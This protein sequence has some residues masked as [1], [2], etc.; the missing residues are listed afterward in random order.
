M[1]FKR[2]L[3]A[4]QGIPADLLPRLNRLTAS[5][6]DALRLARTILASR[7]VYLFAVDRTWTNDKLIP[8]FDWERSED[9][10]AALWQGYAWN[11]R[12][13]A[14]LWAALRPLLL[15]TFTPERLERLHS[16]AG[17]LA[18]LL[19]MVGVELPSADVP[20]DR[21]RDAIRAMP[22]EVRR[23]A[24][25]WLC[26]HVE[27]AKIEN[28]TPAAKAALDVRADRL[29]RERVAPWLMRVW[30]RNRDL[31][32]K[33]TSEQFASLAIATEDAFDEAV[34]LL[35]PFMGEAP[36]WGF[37]IQELEDSTHPELRP[38]SSLKLI[39]RLISPKGAIFTT[40]LRVVLDRITKS[41]PSLQ[42]DST[43]R[44]LDAALRT[45]GG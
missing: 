40:S 44:A 23:E 42:Q 21:V 43:Y 32:H 18:T 7:L 6:P 34:E 39:G 24:I 22:P 1:T 15:N 30:P 3:R 5:H 20:A 37:P 41:D 17:N 13:N 28:P 45:V 2:G 27:G 12:I 26:S 29:W 31:V 4:G 9:E 14:D 10:A 16:S 11:G 36:H 35:W 25:A 19:M 8:F 38:R 33:A